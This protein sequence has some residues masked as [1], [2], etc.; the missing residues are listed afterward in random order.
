MFNASIFPCWAAQW[1][2][3]VLKVSSG[4]GQWP[5]SGQGLL[6]GCKGGSALKLGSKPQRQ[7]FAALPGAE[8][9]SQQCHPNGHSHLLEPH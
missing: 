8:L 5:S 7:M 6:L 1:E 4:A 9:G 2:Q 3:D